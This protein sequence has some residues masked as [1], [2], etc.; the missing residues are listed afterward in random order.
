M[1]PSLER[2]ISRGLDGLLYF[3]RDRNDSKSGLASLFSTRFRNLVMIQRNP[4]KTKKKTFRR[5]AFYFRAT[6]LKF[7]LEN[8]WKRR[9]A[10]EFIPDHAKCQR[11]RSD[12]RSQQPC[13]KSI[14]TVTPGTE[15]WKYIP[16][17]GS[18]EL[19]QISQI[20]EYLF[21]QYSH[22]KSARGP[23]EQ[24]DT[25]QKAVSYSWEDKR[26][27]NRLERDWYRSV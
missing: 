3:Y 13:T 10:S 16:C 21:S 26:F 24:I 2:K 20:L 18:Y 9:R 25:F 22:R 12:P 8:K 7:N 17:C 19:N 23:L 11:K 1:Q 4:K 5:V 6:A 15:N 27:R 14:Q